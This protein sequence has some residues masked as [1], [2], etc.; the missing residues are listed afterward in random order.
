[1]I[2]LSKNKKRTISLCWWW[3]YHANTLS[4][5]PSLGLFNVDIGWYFNFEFYILN[6]VLGLQISSQGNQ[7][8][9]KL[10]EIIEEMKANGESY[11]EIDLGNP[12]GP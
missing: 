4:L 6:W 11:R 9:K 2:V 12:D 8:A 10:N 3:E 7:A 1:M 5:G